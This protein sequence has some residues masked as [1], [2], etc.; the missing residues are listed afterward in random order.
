MVF[1]ELIK[2]L[3]EYINV[4]LLSEP[5]LIFLIDPELDQTIE[6]WPLDEIFQELET[7]LIITTVL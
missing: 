2:P 6:G 1:L 3:L 4:Y 7:V 5:A